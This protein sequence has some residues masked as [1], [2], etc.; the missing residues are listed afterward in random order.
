MQ[1]HNS[2]VCTGP[3]LQLLWWVGGGASLQWRSGDCAPV[4]SG[5]D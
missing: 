5:A 3:A 1:A 2:I 4:G